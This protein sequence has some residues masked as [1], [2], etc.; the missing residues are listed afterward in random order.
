MTTLVAKSDPL[1]A[2]AGIKPPDSR[3]ARAAMDL[4]RD[5]SSPMAGCRFPMRAR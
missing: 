2:V 5:V 3:I 4:A 1:R